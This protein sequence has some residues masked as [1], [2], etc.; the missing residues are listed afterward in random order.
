MTSLTSLV[1]IAT[2]ASIS[3][4]KRNLQADYDDLSERF[5]RLQK[6]YNVSGNKEVIDKCR[7]DEEWFESVR[8]HLLEVE[9]EN[10]KLKGQLDLKEEYWKG[11]WKARAGE[12]EKPRD[13]DSKFV[14]ADGDSLAVKQITAATLR[15]NGWTFD[16]IGRRIGVSPKTARVYASQGSKIEYVDIIKSIGVME[17]EELKSALPPH[18]VRKIERP[19][20]NQ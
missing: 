14:S 15:S 9:R 4:S 17:Y 12:N 16:E 20:E 8:D 10:A 7:R 5:E 6:A 13:A 1:S 3:S 2:A 11:Y 18:K 19:A